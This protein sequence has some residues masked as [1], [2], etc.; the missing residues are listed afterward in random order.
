MNRSRWISPLLVA[1]TGLGLAGCGQTLENA[2]AP[3]PQTQ[4]WSGRQSAPQ[5]DGSDQPEQIGSTS[6]EP[7]QLNAAEDLTQAFPD[8]FVDLEDTPEYLRTYVEDLARLK[9]LNP[10]GE[11][12]DN[13]PLLSPNQPIKR[14]TFVRWL[15]QVRNRFNRDR[16]TQQ[17]RLASKGTSDPIFSDV[18]PSHPDFAY[19]QGLAESGY[20]PSPLTGDTAEEKF[21]P[22]AQLTRETLLRWKVPVDQQR[23]LSTVTPAKVEETWGFK[24]AGKVNPSAAS[25][26]VADYANQDLSN[27]RRLVGSSLLLRPQKAVTRAEAAA[28]LWYFGMDGQGISAKDIVRAEVQSSAIAESET[29]VETQ[30]QPERAPASPVPESEAVDPQASTEENVSTEDN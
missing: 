19:I 24:D 26:I 3:D 6:T 14:S 27:V 25:A 2:L 18:P 29:A 28:T 5:D 30:S 7:S 15:V 8:S 10:W 22:D 21:R 11:T 1:A 23:L 16:P 9:V 12:A 17:F 13:E 20:L 4:T